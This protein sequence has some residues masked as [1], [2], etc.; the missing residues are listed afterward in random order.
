MSRTSTPS[1]SDTMETKVTPPQPKLR[2][3]CEGCAISKMKCPRQKPTCSRCAKRGLQCVYLATRRGGRKSTASAK[4]DKSEGGLSPPYMAAPSIMS[5]NQPQEMV[6]GGD[7]FQ[8]P[9]ENLLHQMSGSPFNFDLVSPMQV[10]DMGNEFDDYFAPPKGLLSEASL[11]DPWSHMLAFP[12]EPDGSVQDPAAL[13]GP[14]PMFE[15]TMSEAASHSGDSYTVDTTMS[16]SLHTECNDSCLDHAMSLVKD[17]SCSNSSLCSS[18]K[19]SENVRT[20][21]STQQIIATNKRTINTV[22]TILQCSCS[23]DGFLLSMLLIIVVRILGWYTA[24]ARQ[25]MPSSSSSSD[26]LSTM[27]DF[28][29]G[30]SVMTDDSSME[31]S[32][33]QQ[34]MAGRQILSELHH[35]QRLVKTL[36][37]RMNQ[38]TQQRGAESL[39]TDVP[40]SFSSA[41]W[42][43]AEVDLRLKL[44]SLSMGIVSK[45]RRE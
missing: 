7:W 22:S 21:P 36:C 25:A 11:L 20:P 38:Q 27:D 40:S 17:L 13:F 39:V 18:A 9:E 31:G 23:R 15:N 34:Y 41:L 3:S 45:L 29:S 32:E 28:P 16:D 43:Q 8:A 14:M 30:A 44:K 24:V 35:V 5:E 26:S 2:D 33:D 4:L 6:F 12:T 37:E 1:P 10:A 42:G 19:G